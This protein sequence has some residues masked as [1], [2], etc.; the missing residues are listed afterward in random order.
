MKI[1]VTG[2]S[3]FIGGTV[4]DLLRRKG[5]DVH[6]LVRGED[7]A[8]QLKARDIVPVVGYL[9]DT[10]L[11]MREAA[12]ADG[13][14]NAASSMGREAALALV[15]GLKDS[16]K[17]I[18]HTSGTGMISRDVSG[19][20]SDEPEMR[21]DQPVVPGDH[22]A[23]HALRDVELAI[24]DGV[25]TGVRASVISNPLIYGNG[26]GIK[27]DSV[28][29]PMMSRQAKASGVSGYLGEGANRWSTVHVEDMA[30]LYL[31]A[32]ERAPAGSFYFAAN[33]ETAFHDLA[34]AIA[35]RL[36]L[37]AARSFDMAEAAAAWGEMP[38][39]YLLGSDSR[40][41]SVRGRDELGWAPVHG[42]AIDWIEQEMP[43]A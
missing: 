26:L 12:R 24:L 14:I 36:G 15:A 41:C 2:A 23:Q 31:R 29:I 39:R 20:R 18:V 38:A 34:A 22:P 40:A 21:D 9:E 42:S 27:R 30:D 16:G 17:P 33:G 10:A 5:H 4:A 3:G 8:E 28:H 43:I 25:N 11:L 37:G 19:G 35:K 6:G 32:L 7:K 1:F 13:V